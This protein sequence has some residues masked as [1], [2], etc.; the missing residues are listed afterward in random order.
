MHSTLIWACCN[1][2]N[3]AVA[4]VPMVHPQQQSPDHL[5]ELFWRHLEKD[6][7]LLGKEIG[8]GFDETVVL[9]HLVLKQILTATPLTGISVLSL[10]PGFPLPT[11]RYK[12][13][14]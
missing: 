5:P 9:V 13:T 4:F 8:R 12:C 2:Q 14:K 11:N 6:V 10:V 7:E 3:A 1:Q